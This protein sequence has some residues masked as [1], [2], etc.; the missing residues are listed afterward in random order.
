MVDAHELVAAEERIQHLLFGL[1][2][3]TV[4]GQATGVLMERYGL[5]AEVAFSTLLRVS[6][7][8]NRKA[9]DIA[10]QLLEEGRPEG[11]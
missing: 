6:Q 2:H 8:R 1:D 10:R 7:D 11:L 5:S 4:L 9:H 3:R